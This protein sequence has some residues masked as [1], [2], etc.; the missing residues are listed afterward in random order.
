VLSVVVAWLNATA[1]RGH[2]LPMMGIAAASSCRVKS[3][4]MAVHDA[5]RSSLRYTRSPP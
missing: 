3:P 5:P 1:S 4:L 2:T